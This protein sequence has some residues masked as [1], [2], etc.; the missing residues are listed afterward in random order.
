MANARTTGAYL[1]QRLQA[2]AERH[3][4]LGR[5]HGH[6][7]L[8]G[9]EVLG[10]DEASARTRTKQIVNR[11][12]SRHRVLIGSEGPSANI[13]KLRPPMPFRPE[14]V[15]LAVAAIAAVLS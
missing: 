2:L 5:V 8:Q 10:P 4:C 15:D 12:A 14:H 11:L 1:R 7:L 9:L 3:A 6:G 13:L